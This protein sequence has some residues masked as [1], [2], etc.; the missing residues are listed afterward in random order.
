MHNIDA[1]RIIPDPFL[2]KQKQMTHI[3]NN[4]KSPYLVKETIITKVKVYYT[5]HNITAEISATQLNTNE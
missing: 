4:Y 2:K 3:I 5:V 1:V